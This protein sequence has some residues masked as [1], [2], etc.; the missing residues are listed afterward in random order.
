MVAIVKASG[1][2]ITT[3]VPPTS[4]NISGLLAGEALAAGDACYIKTSDG[5]VYRSI[6]TALNAAAAVDGYVP[7]DTAIG[8]A[9]SLYFHVQFQ[10][11]AALSPGTFCYLSG[12]VPGGLDTVASTGGT[13]AIGR[14]IDAT[15][16]RLNLS[17]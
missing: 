13:M 10:Y 7:A 3:A 15:R 14:V 12:T 16:I 11:G 4:C 9:L 5:R 17:Y 1:V 8:E 6:G 2:S